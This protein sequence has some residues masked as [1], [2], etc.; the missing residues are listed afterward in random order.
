MWLKINSCIFKHVNTKYEAC[1]L[2]N[3]SNLGTVNE[4]IQ[5]KICKDTSLSSTVNVA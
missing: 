2:S 1:F 3:L 4:F 5:N